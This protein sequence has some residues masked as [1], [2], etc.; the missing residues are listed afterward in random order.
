MRTIERHQIVVVFFS[1]KKFSFFF[2]GKKKHK[3]S[4]TLTKAGKFFY[5]F[6]PPKINFLKSHLCRILKTQNEKNYMVLISF[7][8]IK[9]IKVFFLM[10]TN[11]GNFFIIG[12]E[13][14]IDEMGDLQHDFF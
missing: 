2:H 1:K 7:F 12:R 9:K 11:F 4:I 8:I 5:R 14:S 10:F 13:N 3:K 6:F